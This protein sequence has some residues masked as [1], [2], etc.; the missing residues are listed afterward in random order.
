MM[1]ERQQQ[2]KLGSILV[3]VLEQRHIGKE[4]II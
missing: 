1:S 3:A 4:D 2:S